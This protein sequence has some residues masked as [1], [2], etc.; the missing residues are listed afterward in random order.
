MET[1]RKKICFDRLISHR[2]GI[3][4]YVSKDSDDVNIKYVTDIT[5]DSNYGSFPCDFVLN[6]SIYYTDPETGLNTRKN[7]EISRLR[8]ADVLRW[9][10]D[11][12]EI[13]RKGEFLNRINYNEYFYLIILIH[14]INPI[15]F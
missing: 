11:V 9:Y 3:S 4:P 6:S 14:K 7:D 15:C 13:I 1:I 8:Y 5:S 10:N 12:N 2:N